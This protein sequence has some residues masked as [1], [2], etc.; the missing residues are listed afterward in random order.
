MQKA[1]LQYN[2]EK[3]GIITGLVVPFFVI[4][5]FYI[6][7]G[8]ESMGAFFEKIVSVGI[9]SE[10]VS[11]CVVPNLLLFFIFMWTNRL[12]SARG[13]IGATFIYA[14]IVLGLKLFL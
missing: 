3:I 1:S 7:R 4:I 8:S 12:K 9:F 14:F 2:T 13:V 6:Y 11:L 10:L 5:G